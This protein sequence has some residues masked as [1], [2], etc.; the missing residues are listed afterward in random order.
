MI[1]RKKNFEDNFYDDRIYID[2]FIFDLVLELVE[3]KTFSNKL[4]KV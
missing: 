1:F 4:L 3:F 2:G